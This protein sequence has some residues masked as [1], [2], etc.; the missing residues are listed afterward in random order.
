MWK[1]PCLAFLFCT[2]LTAQSAT[3]PLPEDR[4]TGAATITAESLKGWLTTLTSKEFAG[5]GTGSDGF[6][7]AAELMRDHFES[8]GLTPFGDT[9]SEPRSYW[10]KIP[11]TRT[12]ADPDN[13][14]LEV[15]A[16]E[17]LV[18]R[19]AP[20]DGLHG[21]AMGSARGAG[22]LALL[23]IR[24]R[25][26][27]A[28]S[29][30]D[31]EGKIVVLDVSRG[32]LSQRLIREIQRGKPA[33]WL[34]VDDDASERYPGLAG[35]S[36]PGAGAANRAV[37][38]RGF[39]PN[40]L[41]TTTAVLSQLLAAA[42]VDAPPEQAT[43]EP[44]LLDLPGLTAKLE[45][46][47]LGA[48]AP[49]YNVV[50]VLPGSDPELRDEYVV[51]GSHLDHLGE[52]RGTIYPGADDDGSGSVGVMAVARAFAQNPTRPRRSV[53]FVTFC[54]EEL[55]L[56]GSQ[57]FTKSPPIALGS[58]VA[59]LQMDMI[60]RNEELGNERAEDNVNSLHLIGTEKL[61]ADLHSLC[62]ERNDRSAGF[63]LEWDEEDVFYRSDHFSFAREGVPIAFFF[64]G[65]HPDY[66]KPSDT[67]EKI[68]FAK[69]S[70]IARYVYDIAFELAMAD[71][72]PMVDEERWEKL[73]PALR[74]RA[75]D[76]PAAPVRKQ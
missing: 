37:R 43:D 55:G 44:A 22:T 11:W 3:Q 54:G 71:D 47:V 69:L 63:D 51:I 30:M 73:K 72:R 34:A 53:M 24:E 1:L 68:N 52:R 58:I 65:F 27:D 56:V 12:Q 7:R 48:Q 5:R 23:S 42:Q 29:D 76:K 9:D 59:Q 38:G 61:S 10:Q 31:L 45:V 39:A 15:R 66:H 67:V 28:V 19:L 26:R 62:V 70:R 75:P 6:G 32:R 21:Q 64:T 14:Y 41:Y 16:G 40:R 8:L 17:Q 35:L 74:G 33:A 18:C 25:D 57:F 46:N 36:R 60:G 4:A 20:G 49:A 13:T 50:G 2:P